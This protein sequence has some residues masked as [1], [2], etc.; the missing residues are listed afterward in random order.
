M[1]NHTQP[2]PPLSAANV[3]AY[4]SRP[5]VPTALWPSLQNYP[6]KYSEWLTSHIYGIEVYGNTAAKRLSKLEVLNNN[7]LRNLQHKPIKTQLW[8][9]QNLL[10]SSNRLITWISNYNL[11][12]SLCTPQERLPAVFNKYFDE[13]C[14]Y[15]LS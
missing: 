1:A 3:K 8:I 14:I 10:H 13:K 12:A 7:L 4:L 9:V 2:S 5:S 6:K 11:Y 15:S